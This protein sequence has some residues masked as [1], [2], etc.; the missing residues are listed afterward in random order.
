MGDGDSWAAAWR[1][2]FPVAGWRGI[3][4]TD[5]HVLLDVSPLYMRVDAH[6]GSAGSGGSNAYSKTAD[7]LH[8]CFPGPLTSL[9]PR[10]LLTLFRSTFT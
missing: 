10:L 8:S 4:P 9:V 3:I 1:G 5:R 2:P 6:I 7:C